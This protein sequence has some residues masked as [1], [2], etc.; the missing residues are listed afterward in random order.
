MTVEVTPTRIG[1]L[2]GV[3]DDG[4]KLA[5]VYRCREK[6][7]TLQRTDN[8][9]V[10][11]CTN[12]SQPV[13]HVADTEN[14]HRA[15]ASGRCVMVKPADPRAYFLGMPGFLDWSPKPLQWDE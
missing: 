13:F 7:E 2:D 9:Q 5:V 11:Y 1:V 12:C 8:D 10:R 14:F 4:R 6:W 3:D 15:V